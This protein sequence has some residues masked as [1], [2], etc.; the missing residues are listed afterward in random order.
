MKKVLSAWIAAIALAPLAASAVVPNPTV[1]GPITGGTK[2]FPLWDSWYEVGSLGYTQ[3]EYFVEGIARQPGSATTASYRTRI[4]VTRPTDP[5]KFNG[6][7][8][9]DW[10]NVTAQFENAVDSVESH[11]YLVREGYAFVHVSAQSAGICCLPN[12]TP[13]TWDPVRY[14]LPG[15]TDKL[16]H[17][18][19]AYALDMFAQIAQALRSPTGIDAMGGLLVQR[20]VATGQS[21]SAGKLDDYLMQWQG[22]S[23]E[24]VIDAFLIHGR[25]A[26]RAE[27]ISTAANAKTTR[28]LQL[29]SDNEAYQNAPSVN[30]YYAQWDVAGASH[31]SFWI[32]VHSELGEGPRFAGGPQRPATA[33]EDLHEGNAP[34]AGYATLNYGEQVNPGQPVCILQGNQFPMHYAVNAAFDAIQHWLTDGVLP[35]VSPRFQFSGSSLAR[36]ADSNALGGI[37][38]A[39]IVHPVASYRST[40]CGPSGLALGGTTVPFTEPQ[41]LLRYPTHAD[42]AC[43]MREATY[44]NV[45]DGFLLEQDAP[46]LLSRVDAAVNRWPTAPGV[47]DCDDD[48]IPDDVDNCPL[49]ANTDQADSGGVNTTTPDGIGDACQCGDVTGN[50]I[51]NGQDANAIKRHGLGQEPNP[52]YRVPGNCDVTGNGQCNGQDGNAVRVV[53]IGRPYP[54]FGQ[55]CQNADPYAP[56]CTNCGVPGNGTVWRIDDGPN[57]QAQALNAFFSATSGDTIEFGEGTFEFNTTLLAAGDTGLPKDGVTVRGQGPRNTILDFLGSNAP[58]GLSF[59]HMDGLTI[60]NLTV[61]DTPGFSLKVSDSNHVVIRNV[62]TMWS[63]ADTNP[64]DNVDDRG[65]MDPKKP[66]TLDV[67][68]IEDPGVSFPQSTGTYVDANGVTRNYVPSS[69]NGG[70]AIY[71]VLSSNVLIDKSVALGAS[72]AGIYVGQSKSVEIKRSE[73]LFNVAGFEIENTDDADVHDNVAHCNTGGF[74]TF[75]LPGL[76]NY[77]DETRT[78]HNRSVFNNNPNFAPGG[79]VSGVPQGVGMLQLGYDEHEI[80][81]NV[82]EWNR[83][84]GLVLASHELLDGNTNNA[85]KR[86]DLYPEAVHVYRNTFTTNGTSPQPPEPSV[87]V[88]QPGTGPGFDSVPPCIPTGVND[89]DTSLLPA[90][91]QIKGVLAAQSG[92][93]YGPTGAH[94]VWDGYYDHA[95]YPCTNPLGSDPASIA[96]FNSILDANG[97]PQYTGKHDPLCRYN[98]YKF[99]NPTTRK[100]KYTTLCVESDNTFSADGRTYMN[101]LGTDPTVAPDTNAAH[102]AC[103]ANTLDPI[104]AAVVEAYTPGPPGSPPP[105]PAEI[106]AICSSYGGNQINRAALPYNCQKLSQYNLFADPTDPRSGANEGGT[107]FELTTQLFS[108]YAKKYRFAFLPPG[109]QAVWHEGSSSAPNATLGFPIGTVIAK[110][111]AFPNGANEEVVET[112]LLIHRAKSGG[113]S[114]WEGMAF[115]WDKDGS[116][117]RTDAHL[118]IAGGT[119]SVAWNYQ[120]PDPDVNATYVGST[121]RYLI[122]QAAQCD[123][124]HINDDKDPGDSP[125]GLKVRLLNRPVDYGSGAENQ[126]QHWVASGMLSGAPALSV[127][128]SQ[129]ATNVQ[130]IPRFNVPGDAANIP[131]SEPGRLAQM[132]A[133][134]ID[135]ELRARGFIETNCAHCHNRDGLAQSTGV[136]FDI[137]RHVNLNYAICKRPTTSGSSSGGNQYDI[138][139]GHPNNSIVSFRIHSTDPSTQMPPIARSVVANEAVGVI[140]DW[141]DSVVDGRYEGSGCESEYP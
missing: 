93:P 69:S 101:F 72:D 103:P 57:E 58:E 45:K 36:D 49:V 127:N 30:P 8:V 105:T 43:Q 20:I 15:T 83:S 115:I 17:P 29:N 26:N 66:S 104:D 63:S 3:A 80:F 48:G 89:S 92:D 56:T 141:I 133:A 27:A 22:G 18:G 97:K 94:I 118:A 78:Y 35:P 75:D 10:V 88:C 109:Q 5:A 65:G 79:V 6:T 44:Q 136:F 86:M 129:V 23:G 52:T 96:E 39:P 40:D 74:L 59:S 28:V 71:P 110:T 2:G 132:S 99:S 102:T 47:A 53:A 21:Q 126:L 4:I 123:S 60:E 116:G 140:D 138:V 31:S 1:T 50:G 82:I 70:Y 128:G 77:G 41:L 135:K 112:R 100:P 114:Y 117:H 34:Y 98:A 108:D 46:S 62:R 85:D 9:M 91:I 87:I 14:G 51:V 42:Y 68:C 61:I 25:V 106:D 107:R 125:I 95:P 19:D 111:F 90:L 76:N 38:L 13:Q 119:A 122:P 131:A 134:E 130:R 67:S 24:H 73:A 7:V 139:P 120:D 11:D 55:N 84:V 16:H 113:G 137:F 64:T 32:G 33:D 12:F 124:C 121:N 37:R 81:D 54:L